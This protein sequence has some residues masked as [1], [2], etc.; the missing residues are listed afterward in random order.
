MIDWRRKMGGIN[1]ILGLYE[2]KEA[3]TKKI[4]P[5]TKNYWCVVGNEEVSN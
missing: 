3:K 1:T 4:I 5:Y 2:S